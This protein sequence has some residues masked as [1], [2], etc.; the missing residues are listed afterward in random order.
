MTPIAGAMI[1]IA[2][3]A[4][5]VARAMMRTVVR[6]IMGAMPPAIVSVVMTVLNFR[7][8]SG[9][10]TRLLDG[11]LGQ[12]LDWGGCHRIERRNGKQGTQGSYRYGCQKSFHSSSP[13]VES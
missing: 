1:A 3:M 13:P 11:R 8:A 12:R 5:P 9:L 7:Q 4:V 6:T 10:L 2:A